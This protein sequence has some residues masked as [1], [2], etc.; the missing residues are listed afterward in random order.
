MK[1]QRIPAIEYIRGISM[2]GVIGIHTGSQYLSNPTSNIHLVAM[3]EI[4]TRFSV[5]IFFFISAFGLFYNLNLQDRFDYRDFMRRRFKTVLVPY[6]VWSLFYI[7]QYTFL[8]H[9][10]SLLSPLTF[11][12][13]L[14]FGFACYQLYFLVI[15]L[16]F[17]LFMP[18]WIYLIKHMNAVRL[19]FLL[20]LQIAFDYYSSF[21]MNPYGIENPLLKALLVYRLNYWVFHYV[22]IFLLG[23]W[24]AVHY[25]AF[26][27]FMQEK[28]NLITIFF[29]GSMTALLAYYYE[30]IFSRGYTAEEAINTAHQL[31]PAGI[32]YTIAASIFFFT[33]FSYN[34]Y[35][36]RVH[37]LLSVLG[38]HSYFAYLFHPVLITY[39]SLGLA[40]GNHVMTGTIAIIFY[41]LVAAGSIAIGALFRRLGSK[42]PLLNTLTIGVYP[43]K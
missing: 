20:L 5:P 43:K 19:L 37:T 25:E 41:L 3:F 23:G 11:L 14:F 38:R 27:K 33:I 29:F 39:L 36:A 12:R 42:F 15:M 13:Y 6:L 16:W 40:A 22:F 9:D 34:N 35:P 18:V 10:A 24:L 30:L 8:Y 26:Q 28:R 7:L 17:Y 32:F 1:K 21:I 4:F 31:S 2:L